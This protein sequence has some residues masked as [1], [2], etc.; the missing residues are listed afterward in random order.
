MHVVQTLAKGVN[1]PLVI[2]GGAIAP[3][4]LLTQLI[5]LHHPVILHSFNLAGAQA[6]QQYSAW[7]A[8]N[9]NTIHQPGRAA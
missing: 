9:T 5:A 3:R 8:R 7:H 6:H 1:P 4:T 2:F